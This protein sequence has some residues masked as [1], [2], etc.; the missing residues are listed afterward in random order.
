MLM[1]QWRPNAQPDSAKQ[2]SVRF[3][4]LTYWSHVD[5]IGKKKSSPIQIGISLIITSMQGIISAEQ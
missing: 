5:G 4:R 3:I 2:L 1:M